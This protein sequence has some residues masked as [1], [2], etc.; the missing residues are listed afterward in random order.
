MKKSIFLAGAA[1]LV[2]GPVVYDTAGYYEDQALKSNTTNECKAFNQVESPTFSV[3]PKRYK[4]EDKTL[5]FELRDSCELSL[6][7]N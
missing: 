5:F 7:N 1:C 4:H 3:I 6:N 2:L